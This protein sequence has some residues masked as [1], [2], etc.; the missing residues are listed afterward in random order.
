M[1]KDN[2]KKVRN[3]LILLLFII[4]ILPV[5]WLALL[6]FEGKKPSVTFD[7]PYTY[8]GISQE[9]SGTVSDQGRGVRKLWISIMKDGR[10]VDLLV[11][12]FPGTS[13]GKRGETL[14]IPFKFMIEPQNLGL[15]DGKAIM[16]TAVFDY[17]WR[18][19]MKGNNTYL[20]KEIIIDT[21]PP[22]IDV[23]STNHNL[24]QGGSGLV[25]YRTSEVG[26][27]SGVSVGGH[28]FPGHPGLF[29]EKKIYLAFF[30]VNY[31]QSPNTDIF[32]TATDQAGN[33]ARAGFAHYIKRKKFVKDT[34]NISDG[35]LRMKMPEFNLSDKY[36]TL[37]DQYLEVNRNFR[38]KNSN[39]IKAEGLKTDNKIHWQ[40]MFLRMKGKQQAGFAD[41]RTY[42]YKG[43]VVDKQVHLGV[44]LADIKR[45]PVKASNSGKVVFIGK[46]GIYGKTV[47][48]DHGFGLLSTYSH[49][50]EMIA[51]KGEMVKKGDIIGR[52]GITGLAGGDHLHFGM[53]IH[54]TFVNPIEWWD[55]AW[56]RNNIT[57]KID[58]VRSGMGY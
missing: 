38:K 26:I 9:I 54:D 47:I 21:R 4:I 40:G 1:L 31:R 44:D 20:E 57:D 11:K 5:A 28:F 32:V 23:L 18:G 48:I 27:K 39:R 6:Q 46:E 33:N 17:S 24:T 8:I 16:K 30:S 45:A 15:T 51:K 2:K 35:F 36:G 19:L 12:T 49:L 13:I 3:C 10:T 42:K 56:I 53:L 14:Q 58:F 55:A 7:F 43:K 22:E 50:S 41:Y 29:K 37:I 52:T 25:I 34:I